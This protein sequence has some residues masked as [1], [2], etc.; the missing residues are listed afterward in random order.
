MIHFARTTN[1]L[2]PVLSLHFFPGG[3]PDR[4][5]IEIAARETGRFSVGCMADDHRWLELNLDGLVFDLCG[6]MPGIGQAVS[7]QRMR[8]GLSPNV[9]VQALEA[10]TLSAGP[11]LL[12][13]ETM[14]PVLRGQVQLGLVLATLPGLRAVGWS[15]AASLIEPARF[16]KEATMWLDGGAL[17]EFFGP[18]LSAFELA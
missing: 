1:P 5:A 8:F 11:N 13:G 17:P 7:P 4:P 14:S 6:L 10:V 9:T 15:P 2:L 18:M 16:S 3:R 12:G